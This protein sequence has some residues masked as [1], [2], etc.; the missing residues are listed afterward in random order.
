MGS[1]GNGV[2][3]SN[4]LKK[5]DIMYFKQQTITPEVARLMLSRNFRNRRINERRVQ[6]LTSD[7][8]K[9]NWTDT[10]Q[11]IAVDSDG[12]LLDGQHRLTAVVKANMPVK[13]TV[14]YDVPKNAVIDRV[15]E[16]SSGEALYMRNLISKPMSARD[17][18]AVV[19]RYLSISKSA[20]SKVMS[21]TDK[22]AFINQNE[23]NILKAIS[24]S[25]QGASRDALCKRAG[26]QTA[27]FAALLNGVN[28]EELRRFTVAVN[29]GFM[30]SAEQSAAIILRNY[31]IENPVTGESASKELC[32]CAQMAI[33]DFVAKNPRR[34]KYRRKSH[35]YIKT[36]E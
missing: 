16:R 5:G 6:I 14:A 3:D 33:R 28:E 34:N 25:R 2:G 35:I 7:I 8:L 1:Q 21:D 29:T 30:E 26:I 18:Q 24:L 19:N 13:M 23:E 20:E 15:L 32:A 27:L 22:V 12:N 11:P 9:G 36:E 17:A 31:T 4:S 10:P